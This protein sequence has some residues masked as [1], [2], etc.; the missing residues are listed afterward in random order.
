MSATELR[1]PQCTA[2]ATPASGSHSSTGTQSATKHSSGTPRS[3]V[4]IPSA[5]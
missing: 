5:S 4:T 3:A 2:A 1:Q